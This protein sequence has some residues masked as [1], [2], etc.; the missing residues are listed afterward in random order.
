MAKILKNE[1]D[2]QFDTHKNAVKFELD[3]RLTAKSLEL[4]QDKP[5]AIEY[6][7][8]YTF[9]T[10]IGYVSSFVSFGT[11]VFAV[12][13]VLNS[14]IGNI[15][16]YTVGVLLCGLFEMVK[17][18][19]WRTTIKNYNRYRN[20]GIMS[21]LMLVGL[22]L[23]SLGS[24]GFGAFVLPLQFVHTPAPYAMDTTKGK[25]LQALDAQ[26]TALQNQTNSLNAVLINP[27]TGKKS[28]STAKSIGANNSQ[29]QALQ[30]QKNALMAALET[31]KQ[32][33]LKTQTDAANAHAA[34]TQFQQLSSLV[35]SLIFEVLF[36]V[37]MLFQFY[38][39]FRVYVDT[40]GNNQPARP[41]DSGNFVPQ[42]QMVT[43]A[44]APV[45]DTINQPALDMDNNTHPHQAP[46]AM[47]T[48][49]VPKLGKKVPKVQPARPIGFNIPNQNNSTP[50]GCAT[51]A[52]P[53]PKG[54]T[55]RV[56]NGCATG[57]QL[58]TP[59]QNQPFSIIHTQTDTPTVFAYQICKPTDTTAPKFALVRQKV[60][61]L[62]RAKSNYT[63]NAQ[64]VKNGKQQFT[65]ACNSWAQIVEHLKK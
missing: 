14:T 58:S 47:A 46:P 27:Q 12:A 44:P 59:A 30:G 7:H 48:K 13:Y 33:H 1:Y 65:R 10:L 54:A 28:S 52:Q 51:G 36:V 18:A 23:F 4:Y 15:L 56:R 5:F 38:F 19:I 43:N 42:M 64:K 40:T 8:H 34:N 50:N 17:G 49:R 39:L 57:A 62:E 53:M 22:H 45:L 29:I 6:K 37:C 63:A 26:I 41:S 11:A 35:A 3:E 24:S 9:A 20:V 2:N 55:K 61:L 32:T 25:E 60:Y 21:V 31:D 16:G